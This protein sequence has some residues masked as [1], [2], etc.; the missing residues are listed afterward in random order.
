MGPPY[1]GDSLLHPLVPLES[2]VKPL[3]VSKVVYYFLW[4]HQQLKVY[5]AERRCYCPVHFTCLIRLK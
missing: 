3:N 2:T 5:A 4:C 1:H